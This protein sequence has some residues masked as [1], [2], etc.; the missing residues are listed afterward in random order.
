MRKKKSARNEFWGRPD[1]ADEFDPYLKWLGIRKQRSR[2]THYRLLGLELFESDVDVIA[3]AAERQIRHVESYAT[4]EHK[5]I[6][7][8]VIAEI[9]AA[10]TCLLD[11][12][13]REKYDQ[14]IRRLR[15]ERKK[16]QSKKKERWKGTDQKRPTKQEESPLIGIEVDQVD[17][18]S[19]ENPTF[20]FGETVDVVGSPTATSRTSIKTRSRN[21]KRKRSGF[22]WAGWI[23]GAVGAA[24][25]AWVLVNTDLIDRIQGRSQDDEVVEGGQ[26]EVDVDSDVEQQLLKD[27]LP[28][29]A[30]KANNS[31]KSEAEVEAKHKET[32]TR[33]AAERSER[34]LL[35]SIP[36]DGDSNVA[37]AS[38]RQLP[39]PSRLE[40]REPTSINSLPSTQPVPSEEE[41]K[42]ALDE[43][44]SRHASE[45]KGKDKS[46][47]KILA[48]TLHSGARRQ[49]KPS[50][51]YATLQVST[52]LSSEV[53]DLVSLENANRLMADLFEVDY[54]KRMSETV[55][56]TIRSAGRVETIG[57]ALNRLLDDAYS[58]GQ[59]IVANKM[60]SEAAKL[61]RRDGDRLQH[62]ML[63]D[64]AKDMRAI[65]ALRRRYETV[66]KQGKLSAKDRMTLGQYKCFGVGEW[67]TG[68][69]ELGAGADSTLA[70]V[71]KT[72]LNA[73]DASAF[74][75]AEAWF[76]L[77]QKKK[78]K[79]FQRRA[80]LH[81]ARQKIEESDSTNSKSTE[82]LNM[83]H[84]VTQ[85]VKIYANPGEARRTNYVFSIQGST[86]F[87]SATFS[88][89]R[90]LTLRLGNKS[91]SLAMRLGN[92]GY[93]GMT[94]DGKLRFL[95]RW[96]DS[97][98]AEMRIYKT[99]S[100]QL[101][102]ILYGKAQ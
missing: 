34:E 19:A 85:P 53:G 22:D 80:M 7:K 57:V 95:I 94:K 84:M 41:L 36:P 60:A 56:Q 35:P 54:W 100:N 99:A 81:R 86:S 12:Q 78:Y 72:D 91:R 21:R 55:E 66:K 14:K 75:V 76:K 46:A 31:G 27:D 50:L 8:R 26:G 51:K 32:E 58:D 62:E 49:S 25:F 45:L 5:E 69:A 2:V 74:E 13:T 90:M 11:Q 1:V 70:M 102:N 96:L 101:Q 10:R 93:E 33:I 98:I 63:T 20:D 16:D 88:V 87:D 39:D 23:L 44:R 29:L 48:M 3:T 77:S 4:T 40:N 82:M 9:R 52:E 28:G 18:G 37:N 68:L 65:D 92:G 24:V 83:I 73:T 64:F 15:K 59:F 79:G 43:V 89:S 30:S 42:L 38:N 67:S 97:G 17:V 71:A 6:C 47:K 61:A